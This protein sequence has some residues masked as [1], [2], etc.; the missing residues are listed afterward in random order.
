MQWTR[1][2]HFFQHVWRCIKF[3]KQLGKRISNKCDKLNTF[4]HPCISWRTLRFGE[5]PPP[6]THIP[7][8]VFVYINNMMTTCQMRAKESEVEKFTGSL[9]HLVGLYTERQAGF[10]DTLFQQ[11]FLE[12]LP[13]TWGRHREEKGNIK[14][15]G[16]RAHSLIKTKTRKRIIRRYE[17]CSSTGMTAVLRQQ[18]KLCPREGPFSR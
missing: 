7:I 6:H 16:G 3:L 2:Q 17:N 10:R 11:T 18:P 13:G 14:W 9:S 15:G 1:F 5:I 12:C 8:H 4:K